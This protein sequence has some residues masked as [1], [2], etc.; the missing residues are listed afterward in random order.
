MLDNKIRRTEKKWDKKRLTEFINQIECLASLNKYCQFAI[1]F[2][3]HQ[4]N[5]VYFWVISIETR[6]RC[7]YY[8]MH[9][10]CDLWMAFRPSQ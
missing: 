2:C 9:G 5:L 7:L 1:C 8:V 6:E 3:K 4:V 10:G